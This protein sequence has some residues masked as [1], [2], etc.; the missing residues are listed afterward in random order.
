MQSAGISHPTWRAFRLTSWRNS[1][2]ALSPSPHYSLVGK[3]G[4]AFLHLST[5]FVQQ[6]VPPPGYQT[7]LACN[8]YIHFVHIT[9]AIFNCGRLMKRDSIHRQPVCRHEEIAFNFSLHELIRGPFHPVVQHYSIW[10]RIFQGSTSQH[11]SQ[12]TAAHSCYT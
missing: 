4:T 3:S 9:F 10:V 6:C 2:L 8:L 11:S 12:V 1:V 5:F 7:L